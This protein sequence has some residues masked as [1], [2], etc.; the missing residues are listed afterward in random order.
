MKKYRVKE[1]YGEISVQVLEI[2][3]K[4]RFMRKPKITEVWHNLDKNG[5]YAITWMHQTIRP[6]HFYETLEDAK[7]AINRFKAEPKYTEL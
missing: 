5:R 4:K 3:T 1:C 6:V 7:E 2:E